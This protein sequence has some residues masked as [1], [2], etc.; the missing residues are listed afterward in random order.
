MIT[1]STAKTAESKDTELNAKNNFDNFDSSEL[2]FAFTNKLTNWVREKGNAWLTFGSP[3]W[4]QA[5]FDAQ[6]QRV[7][8]LVDQAASGTISHSFWYDLYSMNFDSSVKYVKQVFKFEKQW[9]KITCH[10]LAWWLQ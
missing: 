8:Q 2:P 1:M 7:E 3:Y 4:D 6:T 5:F 9:N 10:Q